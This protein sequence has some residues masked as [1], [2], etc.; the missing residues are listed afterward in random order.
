MDAAA[1]VHAAP[2]ADDPESLRRAYRAGAFRAGTEAIRDVAAWL[3]SHATEAR[4]MAIR[5]GAAPTFN[6][7]NH[8]SGWNDFLSTTV[9]LQSLKAVCAGLAELLA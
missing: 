6:M 7:P 1:D 3:V 4:G 8:P 5:D 2:N 9:T